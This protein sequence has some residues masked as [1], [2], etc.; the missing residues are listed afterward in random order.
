MADRGGDRRRSRSAPAVSAA[1]LALALASVALV[2]AGAA[3]QPS[4]KR[5]PAKA[6]QSLAD[7]AGRVQAEARRRWPS[8]FAGL[9]IERGRIRVAFTSRAAGI[10]RKLRDELSRKRRSRLRPVVFD[11]SLRSLETLL[12]QA[13]ADRATGARPISAPY[14]LSLDQQRNEIVV[15]VERVDPRVVQDF[16]ARYGPDVIVE[17]G[18]VSA[19][20]ACTIASCLPTL[21]AGLKSLIPK[22]EGL[23]ACTT[24]FVVR[25]RSSVQNLILSS[26]HCGDTD[27][28]NP[29]GLRQHGSPLKTYGWVWKERFAGGVDAE[30][31]KVTSAYDSKQPYV[32]VSDAVTAG[33]VYSYGQLAHL[34]EGTEICKSGEKTG[35]SCGPV[36][37]L[38]FVPY[39]IPSVPGEYFVKTGVCGAPG[40]S[41]APVYRVTKMRQP[42]GAIGYQAQ[43]LLS[44]GPKKNGVAPPCSDPGFYSFFSHIELIH[45]ALSVRVLRV[46]DLK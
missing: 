20:Y 46:R 5:P 45:R 3:K 12:D 21:R 10:A 36:T 37:D 6:K 23:A 29:G 41:G 7:E 40:D 33:R 34:V 43:G 44:G 17:Q 38:F 27:A 24:G 22:P 31:Q 15:T 9:W 1:V 4:A 18:Y 13:A 30:V 42:A 25:H 2:P 35:Y 39:S 28:G 11:D 14:D 8:T 16:R 19:P 32:R 26:A